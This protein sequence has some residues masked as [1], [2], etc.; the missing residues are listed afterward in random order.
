MGRWWVNEVYTHVGDSTVCGAAAAVAA[1]EVETKSPPCE[2]DGWDGRAIGQPSTARAVGL[3]FP[4]RFAYHVRLHVCSQR[5]PHVNKSICL[6]SY[7]SLI[8][9][10]KT[11]SL[12]YREEFIHIVSVSQ[13]WIVYRKTTKYF[14]HVSLPRTPLPVQ[15]PAWGRTEN[16]RHNKRQVRSRLERVQAGLSIKSSQV[17]VSGRNVQ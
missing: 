12:V 13:T 17:A 3:E 16:K 15:L 10:G 9:C 4:H 8:R 7:L 2:G 6:V 5:T 14:E 1:A 11:Q